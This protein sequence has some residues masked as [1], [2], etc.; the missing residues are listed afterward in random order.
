MCIPIGEPPQSPRGS[1]GSTPGV[2]ARASSSSGAS[3]KSTSTPFPFRTGLTSGNRTE[4]VQA[5][6]AQRTQ[7]AAG[8]PV[9]RLQECPMGPQNQ[10][11][12]ENE[13]K[14]AVSSFSPKK[15][16]DSAPIANSELPPFLQN[17]CRQV[18]HLRLGPHSK[19]QESITRPGEG[20]AGLP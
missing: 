7:P 14:A 20:P 13:L 11:L 3:A 8:D 15:A 4:D 10:S 2:G 5:H 19:W 6:P 17:L 16:G 9:T 12:L 18:S 1:A